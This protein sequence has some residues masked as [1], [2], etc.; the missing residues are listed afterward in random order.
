M[1]GIGVALL[2]GA[3]AV[4]MWRWYVRSNRARAADEA[5][6]LAHLGEATREDTEQSLALQASVERLDAAVS[7]LAT[8]FGVSAPQRPSQVQTFSMDIV[9]PFRGAVTR[10]RGD[11]DWLV[12]QYWHTA[13]ALWVD[14]SSSLATVWRSGVLCGLAEGS[15]QFAAKKWRST[16]LELH[17]HSGAWV[18]DDF[19]E[20]A[21]QSMLGAPPLVRADIAV[22]R[23]RSWLMDSS[24][25]Y[26][27]AVQRRYRRLAKAGYS[28]TAVRSSSARRVPAAC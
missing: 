9:R 7:A 26:D 21:E 25:P 1:A 5:R 14:P 6:V 24:D 8:E 27:R 28:P 15:E 13:M 19:L 17:G 3:Y 16:L 10:G 20:A 18:L 12:S 22:V 4:A 2:A 23:E 11:T